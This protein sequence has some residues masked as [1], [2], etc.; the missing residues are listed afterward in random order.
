M[1]QIFKTIS[2]SLKEVSEIDTGCWIN[3][4]RPENGELDDLAQRTGIPLDFLTD[5]LDVD[6]RARIEIEDDFVLIV[7]RI[8]YLDPDK[9][10]KPFTTNQFPGI[11]LGEFARAQHPA[12][13]VTG[14]WPLGV[15]LI[16]V[17]VAAAARPLG[18]NLARLTH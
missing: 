14:I 17:G 16:T 15:M 3:L 1:I 10:E 8:P 11:S 4:V 7:L 9:D 5:P 6:E 18:T 12:R 13:R 2:D